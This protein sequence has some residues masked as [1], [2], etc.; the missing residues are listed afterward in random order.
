MIEVYTDGASSG[1]PGPSGAGVYIKAYGQI[2]QFS[3]PLGV[4]SNHE[5]EFHAVLKAL[6]ICMNHFSGEILSFRSDSRLVVDAVD[7]GFTKNRAYKPLLS[8]IEG[9]ADSFPYFFIKWIPD[10]QNSN[11]DQ[12]ARQ[13]ILMNE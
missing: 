11:A 9:K 7:S 2:K 5:A 1:N 8:A 13:A 6:D 10:K 3:F 12:L 4:M